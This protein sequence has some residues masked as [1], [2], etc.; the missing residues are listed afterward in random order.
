[1]NP[2]KRIVRESLNSMVNETF[3]R[4]MKS[5]LRFPQQKRKL[6]SIAK[7]AAKFQQE[8]MNEVHQNSDQKSKFSN[9]FFDQFNLRIEIKRKEIEKRLKNLLN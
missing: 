2:A 6:N 5:A 9:E 4:C 1:M 8:M 3:N 7:D